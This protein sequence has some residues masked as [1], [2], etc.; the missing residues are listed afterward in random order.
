MTRRVLA[1]AYVVTP[2][3]NYNIV[4][5]AMQVWVN[6][7]ELNETILSTT[8][9]T[10]LKVMLETTFRDYPSIVPSCA[11]PENETVYRIRAQAL[12]QRSQVGTLCIYHLEEPS[13]GAVCGAFS[14][15]LLLAMVENNS[16]ATALAELGT[17]ERFRTRIRNRHLIT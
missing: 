12:P 14:S 7:N 13:T 2:D 9:E 5:R 4:L 10:E 8:T 17:N 3:D 6:V 1:T 15:Q 16:Y 11:L